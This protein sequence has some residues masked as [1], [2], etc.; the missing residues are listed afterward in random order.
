MK[1]H[2]LSILLA[3][4][5]FACTGA[6]GSGGQAGS[7]GP[8]GDPGASVASTTLGVGDTNCPAGGSK[9]VSAS[10]TTYACNGAPGEQGPQGDAGLK[11]DKG[12]QG[13]QGVPGNDATAPVG[14]IIA[15]AGDSPPTGWLLCD[16]AAVGR[17]Q[18][19]VLF[20]TIGVRW[21]AGD[22]VSTFNVPDL[23]GR[24]MRGQDRGSGHD[25]EAAGR[26]TISAGGSSGDSVGSLQGSQSGPHAHPVADPGHDHTP[27]VGAFV[28]TN[29]AGSGVG[30]AAGGIYA[31]VSSPWTPF[32]S[33]T[34]SSTTGV[35][36]SQN[37]GAESRPT[38]VAVNFIIKF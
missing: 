27:A 7:Q 30:F 19:A 15:F 11:G 24:F 4:I 36:V 10:G 6:P 21:G 32:V 29:P 37:S 3:S 12:D 2:L 35:T 20:A 33:T 34:A 1:H 13:I 17:T 18:Y 5:T 31:Y 26:T 16:G 8:Q 38:N 23:R 14:S 9:F 28:V 25:P 22:Y